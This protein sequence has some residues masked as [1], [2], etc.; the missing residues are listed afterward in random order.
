[1]EERDG[2]QE[3][4]TLKEPYRIEGKK[5]MGYE[6]AEQLGWEVPDVILYPA[7]GGVGL[8]GIHKAMLEMQ[9]LGWIGSSCRGWSRC[10]RGDARRSSTPSTR[11]S[12]RATWSR[13]A[14]ARVRDQHAEGAGRLPRSREDNVRESDGT[15]IAVSDDDVREVEVLANKEGTWICPEGAAGAWSPFASS[16]R[17][18][19][20]KESERVVV[21][22]T[23]TGLKYPEVIA[24]DPPVVTEDDI[25]S[26]HGG[27]HSLVALRDS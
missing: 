16:G 17:A 4:S 25:F 7:G 9:E 23:G 14:H 24:S 6:I 3:V 15:A 5:T 27:H 13:A 10:S 1:M 8:I 12:T 18:A 22:N 20:W 2:Y 26:P 21:L 11:G 19:G